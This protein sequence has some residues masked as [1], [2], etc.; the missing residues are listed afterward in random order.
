VL[1]CRSL[2]DAWTVC[3]LIDVQIVPSAALLNLSCGV[4]ESE[5]K[6]SVLRV[7]SGMM[8]A[9]G[10][11][12][13]MVSIS[14]TS[15]VVLGDGPGGPGGGPFGG[16]CPRINGICTNQGCP[17]QIPRCDVPPGA[18]DCTCHQ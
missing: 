10:I 16:L 1:F 3:D 12:L 4:K 18:V 17:P 5:M 11:V 6:S 15:S 2:C 7:L 13:L 14:V 9:C 8:Q